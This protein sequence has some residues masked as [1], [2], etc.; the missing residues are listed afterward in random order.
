MPACSVKVL[1]MI[2]SV[3]F[4]SVVKP[5]EAFI[6]AG[7][8]AGMGAMTLSRF[9][10]DGG[11]HSSARQFIADKQSF[12]LLEQVRP[13]WVI[14][15]VA[16]S[17]AELLILHNVTIHDLGAGVLIEGNAEPSLLLELEFNGYPQTRGSHDITH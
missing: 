8:V 13:Q 10:A 6:R 7:Y 1:F 3:Y 12:A 16:G 4:S 15:L 11:S 5:D 17:A 2:G 14:T 9:M